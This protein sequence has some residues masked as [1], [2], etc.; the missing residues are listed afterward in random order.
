MPLIRPALLL[1]AIAASTPAALACSCLPCDEANTFLSEEDIDTVFVG[2]LISITK[3][4][5]LEDYIP[6]ELGLNANDVLYRFR[7]QRSLKGDTD[8]YIQ[9][10]SPENPASCGAWFSF[11]ALN[12]VAAYRSNGTALRTESC[13]QSCWNSDKNRGLIKEETAQ[14]WR[15]QE[16]PDEGN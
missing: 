1:C 4:N 6:D 9:V 13:V 10:R 7:I 15:W 11:H 14:T 5:M 8:Q 2:E 16:N 12:A 3:P